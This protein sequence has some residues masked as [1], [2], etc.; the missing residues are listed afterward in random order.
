[1][2]IAKDIGISKHTSHVNRHSFAYYMLSSGAIVG[3]ISLAMSHSSI[4][5]T[6]NYINQFP[7]KFSDVA[8]QRFADGWEILF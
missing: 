8:L 7:S 6:Q 3:E 4:E 5:I 1:M 2:R